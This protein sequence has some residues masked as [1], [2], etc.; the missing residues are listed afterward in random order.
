MRIKHLNSITS[1]TLFPYWGITV[2]ILI[3]GLEACSTLNNYVPSFITPLKIEVQQGNVVTIEQ[4]HQLKL[5]MTRDQVR[6]I[7]GTPLLIDP[8]HQERWDYPFRIKKVDGTIEHSTVTVFFNENRLQ[9]YITSL[10]PTPP[11]ANLSQSTEPSKTADPAIKPTLTPVSQANPLPPVNSVANTAEILQF[12]EKWR[13][14]WESR[15]IEDYLACYAEAFHPQG[16]DIAQWR[17][18]QRER[19]QQ[20][21]NIKIKIQDPQIESTRADHASVTFTQIYSSNLLQAHGKKTLFLI[22]ENDQWR[23]ESELYN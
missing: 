20:S 10:T 21:D 8:F 18:E 11:G 19:L 13:Q 5:G 23:I 7:L 1:T 16:T 3:L 9:R 12:I 2:W 17:T 14:A 15:H 22:K 6:F 4:I